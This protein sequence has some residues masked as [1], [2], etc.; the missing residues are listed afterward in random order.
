M[1]R[2]ISDPLFNFSFALKVAPAKPCGLAPRQ[3]EAPA[4]EL[5]KEW[6]TV[7]LKAK[8][9]KGTRTLIPYSLF[10]SHRIASDL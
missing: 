6:G 8:R 10:F 2:Q 5:G 4:H 7:L 1:P 3:G 9:M